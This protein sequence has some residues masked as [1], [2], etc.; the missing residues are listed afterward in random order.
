MKKH[1]RFGNK[2]DWVAEGVSV[3][4]PVTK[5]M[6]NSQI[7][8]YTRYRSLSTLDLVCKNYLKILI[9]H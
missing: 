3:V 5:Q 4:E 7:C 9:R 2:F 8:C 6:F 1:I